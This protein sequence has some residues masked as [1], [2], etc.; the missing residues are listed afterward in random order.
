MGLSILRILH[1]LEVDERN[2][3]PRTA[4]AIEL[5][6]VLSSMLFA[7]LQLLQANKESDPVSLALVALAPLVLKNQ[8]IGCG[9]GRGQTFFSRSEESF[10]KVSIL[11]L[12]TKQIDPSLLTVIQLDSVHWT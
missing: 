9:T 1:F 5:Q 7:I 8:E 2:T 4:E 11:R 6:Q 12:K 3:L 10:M